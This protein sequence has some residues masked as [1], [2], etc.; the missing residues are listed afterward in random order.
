[1]INQIAKVL[2]ILN[3]ETRPSQI[4]LALC[5][6]CIAG[7]T[8]FMSLHNL[9]ILL[10]VLVL[11]VNLSAFILGL[12]CFS[13]IAY[14][15]DPLFHRLGLTLLNAPALQSL[16]TALYNITFFRLLHFNNT[17]IL[18]SFLA[19]LLISIPFFF[20]ANWLIVRYRQTLLAW[21]RKTRIAQAFKL[22][23]I[24]KAYRLLAPGDLP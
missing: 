7:L 9:F 11:R 14:V 20:L 6:S 23:K 22:T 4:S 13:G 10:A 5:F 8:P 24:Y 15:F 16:W 3:S 18:G 17:I 19:A 2:K 12:A 1:M 21:V